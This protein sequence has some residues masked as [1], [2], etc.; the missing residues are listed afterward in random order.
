MDQD[1]DYLIII[2]ACRY[3]LFSR[4][5]KRNAPYVISGG[6]TTQ[7]WL[8]WNF[9]GNYNDVICISSNPRLSNLNLA[10]TFGFNPFF[11]TID[12]WDYGWDNKLRTVPPK[13]VTRATLNMV[14]EYPNKRILIHYNQ[15]HRP[16]IGD[17]EFIEILDNLRNESKYINPELG[18]LDLWKVI[19]KNK[20]PLRRVWIAYIRTLRLVMNEIYKLVDQLNGKVVISSD[21]GNL[22]GEYFKFSHIPHLRVKHLV[23][24]PWLILKND[25]HRFIPGQHLKLEDEKSNEIKSIKKSI[26]A[27]INEKKL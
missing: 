22:M 13:E 7:E 8:K 3:D 1:W 2:D 24:V 26:R 10:K 18:E 16:Y 5:V 9:N 12:V 15:P 23:K 11:K 6:S 20:I 4:F 21:H 27:L 25:K 19:K 17:A 14:E